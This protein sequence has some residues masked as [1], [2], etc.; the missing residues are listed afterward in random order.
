MPRPASPVTWPEQARF[1][2]LVALIVIC[3]LGGGASRLDV[4]SLIY[5]QPFA[6]ICLAALLLVPGPIDWP[7]IRTPL[8][9]LGALAAV[10]AAQLIP[11]PPSLWAAL[12]GRGPFAEI[13][14][15][16]GAGNVWRPISLTPDLT[17][18]SLAGLIVP[19]A[20]LVGFASIP[21]TRAYGLLAVFIIGAALSIFFG[22]AQVAGGERSPFYFYAITSPGI[23]VGL[24]SNRNH[25]AL[26]LVIAWA[27]LAVWAS[28][29]TDNRRADTVRRSIAI[30][31]ALLIP[32][33]L[34]VTGSRAGLALAPV[35]LLIAGL[36]WRGHRPEGHLSDKTR[37]WLM[38][39]IGTGAVLIVGAAIAF[40]RDEALRRFLDSSFEDETRLGFFPV[41]VGIARDFFPV[42]SGFGSFDPVYRFYEPD[43]LLSATYLNHAH[44]DLIELVI[45]GGLPALVVALCFLIWFG[46]NTLA[47]V[48][49]RKAS[50]RRAFAWL[51]AGIIAL[52][53]ASSL[54]DYPLRTPLMSV[55]FALACGWLAQ[56]RGERKAAPAAP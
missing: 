55:L 46:R 37:K 17:L 25:Q 39:G 28:Q 15:G 42:G 48:R 34:L 29:A 38:I 8:L 14:A 31:F 21:R 23:P 45:T 36:I 41:L 22:L 52:I 16:A 9:L 47:A 3:F 49:D 1:G 2:I 18:A 53:L 40:S 20:A 12:P 6:V 32:P 50:R 33:V 27:M 44:N 11:L 26:F 4:L 43:A 13:A 24:F 54:F 10:I 30:A 7:L 19:A 35:G 51:A 56:A 5:V